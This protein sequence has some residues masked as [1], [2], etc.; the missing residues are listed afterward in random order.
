MNNM[1]EMMFRRGLEE[2]QAEFQQAI[3]FQ[4]RRL[5]KL[6]LPDLKNDCMY[7]HHH[8]RSLSMGSS[9]PIPIPANHKLSHSRMYCMPDTIDQEDA[10]GNFPDLLIN[11]NLINF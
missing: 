10:E 8:L 7:N 6:Q 4:G 3:E 9:A 1:H 2:Q 11:T 5:M